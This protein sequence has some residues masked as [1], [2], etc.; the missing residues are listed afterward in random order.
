MQTCILILL[1]MF[2]F[3]LIWVRRAHGLRP[4][5][6]S[7]AMYKLHLSEARLFCTAT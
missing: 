3:R 7:Y 6:N 4:E 5:V 1:I 2:H